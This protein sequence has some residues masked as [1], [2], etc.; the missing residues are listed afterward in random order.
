MGPPVGPLRKHRWRDL[1][2]FSSRRASSWLAWSAATRIRLDLR[3]PDRSYFKQGAAELYFEFKYDRDVEAFRFIVRFE[4]RNT[5]SERLDE[6]L[7]GCIDQHRD[8]YPNGVHVKANTTVLLKIDLTTETETNL[9]EHV[10]ACLDAVKAMVD[11]VL[12]DTSYVSTRED[13]GEGGAATS[14]NDHDG[15]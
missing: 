7:A 2:D 14:N 4:N 6:V 1:V 3:A 15:D 11:L 8:R 13:T 10:D 9:P 12:P 5:V